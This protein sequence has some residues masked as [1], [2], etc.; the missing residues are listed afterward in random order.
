MLAPTVTLDEKVL[1]DADKYTLRQF[2][3]HYPEQNTGVTLISVGPKDIK[4]T[5]KVKKVVIYAPGYPGDAIETGHALGRELVEKQ[6]RDDVLT[7][8]VAYRGVVSQDMLLGGT[9][10]NARQLAA[11]LQ[12]SEGDFT[13]QNAVSSVDDMVGAVGN[14]FPGA[15]RILIASSYAGLF[16]L[17]YLED[18]RIGKIIFLNPVI[19]VNG[20]NEDYDVKGLLEYGVRTGRIKA[21][22]ARLL[23]EQKSLARRFNPVGQKVIEAPIPVSVYRGLQ[24]GDVPNYHAQQLVAALVKAG[25]NFRFHTIDSGDHNFSANS[26]R[27]ELFAKL[28]P[29]ILN[30]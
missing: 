26:G 16:A 9:G 3:P 20:L 23:A 27:D 22:S 18:R 14:R 2:I 8:V 6:K 13:F 24:D 10:F 30:R 4:D 1:A 12:I 11:P 17:E 15:K 7:G 19:D 21:D 5:S 28:I 29:E 25:G